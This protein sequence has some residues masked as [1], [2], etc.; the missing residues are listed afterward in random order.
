MSGSGRQRGYIF[1]TVMIAVVML[2]IGMGVLTKSWHYRTKRMKEQEL[3]FRG[4]QYAR[5]IRLFYQQHK[6][7]PYKLEELSDV[8]PRVIRRLWTEPMT[9]SGNWGLI[10]LDDV[11]SGRLAASSGKGTGRQVGLINPT[12][13]EPEAREPLDEDR[14]PLSMTAGQ[15]VGVYS[16][17]REEAFAD[18]QKGK[19]YAD[20]K[21]MG[22]MNQSDSLRRMRMGTSNPV[23]QR[24]TDE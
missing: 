5:A 4:R 18:F 14:R 19:V 2:S 21:F 15:I 11:M 7:Y 1:I 13:P 17:S 22:I 3:L 12:P 6:R 23:L 9:K 20:W 24:R 8:R 10:Y 16:P